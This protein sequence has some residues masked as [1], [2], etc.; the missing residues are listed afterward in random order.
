M[1]A[2]A[3]GLLLRTDSADRG[4]RSLTARSAKPT[5]Y[6]ARRLY[7]HAT[8][9]STKLCP[10]QNTLGVRELS[11]VAGITRAKVIGG[12]TSIVGFLHT[13]KVGNHSRSQLVCSKP[14]KTCVLTD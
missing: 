3:V 13:Q 12:E 1:L 11:F 14:L 10:G 7:G 9:P 4:G 8:Q 2:A 5:S 6:L